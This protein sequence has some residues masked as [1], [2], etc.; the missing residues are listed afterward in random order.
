MT[1]YDLGAI[2]PLLLFAGGACVVK[3]GGGGVV[4]GEYVELGP[5][6][7]IVFSVGWDPTGGAPGGA[8]RFDAGRGH[9]HRRWR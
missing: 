9:P 8:T 4:R 5:Y 1:V 3:L 2:V 6:E 7:R